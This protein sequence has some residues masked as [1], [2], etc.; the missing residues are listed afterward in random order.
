MKDADLRPS[1]AH[2][3]LALHRS[4]PSPRNKQK[5]KQEM[6]TKLTFAIAASLTSTAFAAFQAPL[7]EFKNEKQLANW[8]AEKSSEHTNQGYTSDEAAFYTGRPY[9][10]TSGGY[11]FHYRS[12]NPEL[13][14][15]TSEDPS[16]FP[17][18]ANSQF[19][20]PVPTSEYDIEGLKAARTYSNGVQSIVLSVF[21]F[22]AFSQVT[23][24]SMNAWKSAVETAWA[25]SGIDQSNQASLSMNVSITFTLSYTWNPNWSAS[26]DNVVTFT[27]AHNAFSQVSGGNTGLWKVGIS[28]Q[29]VVHEVGHFMHAPDKYTVSYPGGVRTTTPEVGW[30]GTIMGA[31]AASASKKDANL[32]LQSLGESVH[33][34]E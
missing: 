5:Q 21:V 33:L 26:Y 16:G 22:D 15:W 14:R 10:P 1:T 20:A 17:D 6:K 27:N 34:F 29:V 19:Y 11:A 9:I 18:G 30:S 7:P 2:S 32:V 25:F 31:G 12:Y 8:R 24:Y 4:H 3:A 28:D 23:N 13:A